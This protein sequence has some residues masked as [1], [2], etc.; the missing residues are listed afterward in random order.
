M[1]RHPR[2]TRTAALALA[3]VALAGCRIDTTP[4][5][6]PD[7]YHRMPNGGLMAN[8][9]MQTEYRDIMGDGI[10][11]ATHTAPDGTVLLGAAPNHAN[12]DHGGH[13]HDVPSQSEFAA[14]VV[15][16]AVQLPRLGVTAPV[17]ATTMTAGQI[18]GPPVAGDL[19]WLSQT[20]RP[21]EVGPSI[22]G[23][24]RALDGA[25]GAYADIE[26]LRP[27]DEFIVVG[28]DGDLLPYRVD[29]V[30]ARAVADRS[31]VFAMGEGRSEVRLVAWSLG[32]DDIDDYVVSAYAMTTE[33]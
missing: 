2:S 8:V 29:T 3:C 24:V 17:V 20:R 25:P 32:D 33:S 10:L 12:G 16:V 23:G 11:L 21:G 6:A 22:F 9:T 26:S 15:P 30:G 5:A 4:E 7:G 31:D 28:E 1:L 14:G 19:A 13:N 18:Q 27:G